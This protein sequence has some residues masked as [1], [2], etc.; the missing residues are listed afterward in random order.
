MRQIRV[1]V[2]A[3]FVI[4]IG[5]GLIAPVLPG[6]A[7]SFNV[8]ITAASAI[9]SIFAVARLLFA[10][11]SGQLVQKLGERPVYLLG[12]AI[13]ALSTGASAAAQNYWQ[14]MVF[15]GLGGIGSTMFTISAMALIIRL[16]PPD[17]R[18]RISSLYTSAFLLGGITG[19]LLGGLLGGLGLRVPFIVYTVALVI[20][21]VVVHT[22][23]K[24]VEG[25][26]AARAVDREVFP[27]REAIRDP[28]YRA[29]LFTNLA[30][31]WATFGVRVAIIP[32]F[33]LAVFTTGPVLAGLALATFSAGMAVTL[34]TAGK[35][36]D[37]IGRKR[38]TV[39]GLSIAGIAT[40]VLGISDNT[41]VF[42]VLCIIAG[43]GTGFFVPSQQA[44]V[45]DLVGS[46]RNGGKV[47]AAYQMTADLGAILGPVLAG[48]MAE[49]ISY[50]AA[51][52]F[53]GVMLLLA[54]VYWIFAPETVTAK[55]G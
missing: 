40:M 25:G 54:A 30:H 32:L 2:A 38:P 16:A 24:F 41:I 51:F 34:I 44:A 7:Q 10:P 29:A 37:K 3:A 5:Y 36:S 50:Q 48:L 17:K 19:P 43:I 13:V 8:G 28:A 47:L 4:A 53:T 6:Y 12:L 1:L 46:D 31:G 35:L 21:I 26:D 39:L 22:Q 15:R 18:G 42:L 9:V 20:A 23:L 27:F 49:Y 11:T 45:A 14:L 33:A 55:R 52:A